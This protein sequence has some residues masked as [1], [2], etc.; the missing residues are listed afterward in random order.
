MSDVDGFTGRERQIA[1]T[2]SGY[3]INGFEH[4]KYP[5]TVGNDTGVDDVNFNS[6]EASE[7]A[8]LRMSATSTMT[9][10]PFIL[11]EFLKVDEEEAQNRTGYID[12]I[13]KAYGAITGEGKSAI[14]AIATS[15]RGFNPHQDSTW[16]KKSGDAINAINTHTKNRLTEAGATTE[17]LVKSVT[18]RAHRDYTGSIALYMP[19]DIQVNDTMMYNE[20]SRK[21]AAAINEIATEGFESF[22]NKAVS[23]SKMAIAGYGTILGKLLPKASGTLGALA[24]YGLG[25]IVSNEMQRSR[26]ALLNPNE[27]VQYTNTQLRTFTFNWTILPDSEYES[28]QA[29][30]L[31]KFFRKSAHAKKNN[32]ITLTVPDHCIVS[33]HGA[34]DMIQLPP[35]VIESVGVTYN[36]NTTSFFKQNNAP[37]EIG[38]TVGLKEMVP[39][40]N[41]DVEMGY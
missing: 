2:G 24:G 28:I 8:K 34:K 31:I 32:Q 40:Y 41:D 14:K 4:W 12:S 9:Q 5:E 29:A 25:D 17:D 13:K 6:H 27:F 15:D 10:E 16:Q 3:N 18:A 21:F 23:T 35:C 11:F 33:F 19:T 30:G 1:A 37:V 38:L 20:D 7:Y 36:P 26:G 22:Q 39:I